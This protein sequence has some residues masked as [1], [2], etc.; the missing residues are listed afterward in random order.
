MSDDRIYIGYLITF[1][2]PKE[3]RVRT[4]LF[5]T[6]GEA[7]DW[8]DKQPQLTSRTRVRRIQFT[9]ETPVWRNGWRRR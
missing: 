7:Y 8:L 4:E 9:N 5:D 6:L 3:H 1:F 2:D